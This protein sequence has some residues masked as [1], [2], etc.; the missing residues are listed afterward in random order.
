MVE[1]FG[2]GVVVEDGSAAAAGSGSRCRDAACWKLS[3]SCGDV[4]SNHT[5]NQSNA[6]IQVQHS[7]KTKKLIRVVKVDARASHAR[8]RR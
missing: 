4:V 8:M 7:W 1:G 5:I 3:R 6:S 2:V